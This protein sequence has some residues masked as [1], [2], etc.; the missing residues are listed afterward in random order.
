TS[1]RQHNIIPEPSLVSQ[2]THVALA[3][4]PSSSFNHDPPSS[5]GLFTTIEEVR[6]KFTTGTKVM[7][8]IGGW[9]DVSG[10]EEAARTVEGREKW[11]KNV[12]VMVE[13]L[14]VDGVDIDWEYPAGNGEDYKQTPNNKREWE[15]KAYPL[16]LSALRKQLPRPLLISA[17]VP[18]LP[19]DM[20]AFTP[21]TMPTIMESLDFLN[22]MTY[23]LMNRRDNTTK[24]HTGIAASLTS[25][26]SYTQLGVPPSKLNL[27][28]AFYIKWYKTGF[29]EKGKEVGCPT[30]LLEDPVTGGDMGRAGAFS[31]HD[32]V[33]EEFKE[34]WGR[35]QEGGRWD[36]RG[37]GW[38]F[39]EWD[40]DGM[41]KEGIWWSWD[42]PEV[43]LKKSPAIIEEKGLGGAFAWGLGEDA[44]RFEHLKA[45]N[46][47]V[48]EWKS[49]RYKDEL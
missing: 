42:T 3:F 24:H 21:V 40:W 36:E 38:W 5:Y 48:E 33:P 1:I 8:A 2:I 22:V 49:V 18:G 45:T 28:F 14:G 35:A 13:K 23:D 17:A 15:I 11:A 26:T 12:R 27:G 41:G 20:I 46:R 9:G 6:S 10:F 19:R 44:P 39:W 47:G 34:S 43:M 32:A 37:G 25:I 30:L 7:V 4:L 16:L 31:W 29:C